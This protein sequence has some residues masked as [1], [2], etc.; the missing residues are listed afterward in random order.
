MLIEIYGPDYIGHP[1]LEKLIDKN[2]ISRLA[3]MSGQEEADAFDR[4]D[5]VALHQ[6]TLRKI[7]I[8]AN[9]FSRQINGSLKTKATWWARNGSSITGALQGVVLHP[10]GI[11]VFVIGAA[12][13]TYI[14]LFK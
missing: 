7:D 2:G 6:S 4:H 10:L 9:I 5:Y 1:R 3:F 11:L 13:A 8:F 14:G 12:L